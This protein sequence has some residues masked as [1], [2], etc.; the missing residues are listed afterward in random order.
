[1]DL[2][3]DVNFVT[4]SLAPLHPRLYSQRFVDQGKEFNLELAVRPSTITDGLKYS[5]ATGK[6]IA[7]ALELSPNGPSAITDKLKSTP[8]VMPRIL[9]CVMKQ[10]NNTISNGTVLL[11]IPR[12]SLF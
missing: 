9:M 5:L 4:L 2:N 11:I 12:I 1:M 7:W 8:Q 6:Y 3:R 10:I